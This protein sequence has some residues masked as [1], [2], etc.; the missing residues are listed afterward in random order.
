MLGLNGKDQQVQDKSIKA[1]QI[2]TLGSCD[3]DVL[4]PV[5]EFPKHVTYT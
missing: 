2:I 3:W 1:R 4:Y 5:W